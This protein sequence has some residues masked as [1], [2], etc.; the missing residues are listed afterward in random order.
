MKTEKKF[1]NDYVELYENFYKNPPTF[2]DN[3]IAEADG[4][5]IENVQDSSKKK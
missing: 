2:E 4:E 3:K 1:I 5:S